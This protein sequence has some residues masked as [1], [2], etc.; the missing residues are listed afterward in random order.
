MF[1]MFCA[2][3]STKEFGCCIS[4]EIIFATF[5][6][7]Y[8][9]FKFR[10]FLKAIVQLFF[11]RSQIQR[12]SVNFSLLKF[13]HA[14]ESRKKVVVKLQQSKFSVLE[15]EEPN[16]DWFSVLNHCLCQFY[17]IQLIIDVIQT[18]EQFRDASPMCF[19]N[20]QTFCDSVATAIHN[21]I[22]VRAVGEQFHCFCENTWV[23]ILVSF[24]TR[25]DSRL[26]KFIETFKW[27]IF[28]EAIIFLQTS[29]KSI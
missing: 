2:A 27:N 20:S 13:V 15:Y 7:H 9:P 22:A 18:L 4:C 3:G 17:F 28:R 8:V 11:R 24:S 5:C 19:L 26:H 29:P 1:L 12:V 23:W 10:F 6:S 21:L 16:N 25:I 14:I